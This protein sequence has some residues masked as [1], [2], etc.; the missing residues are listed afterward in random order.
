VLEAVITGRHLGLWRG[1]PPTGRRVEFPLCAIF[2]F[3]KADLL[4]GE[5]IYYDR[6]TILRQLGMFHEPQHILGRINAVV[7]H[8]L[9]I[10]RA[11]GRMILGRGLRR[12]S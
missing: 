8:P 4:A 12:G 6:A 5:K 10:A 2:T 9:T 11:M 7:M 1:L 3:D